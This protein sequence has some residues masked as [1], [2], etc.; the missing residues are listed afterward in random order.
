MNV[1]LTI[2]AGRLHK[3]RAMGERALSNVRM[4]DGRIGDVDFGRDALGTTGTIDH[5]QLA[6]TPAR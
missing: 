1:E 2:E 4:R 5:T 6:V 3:T